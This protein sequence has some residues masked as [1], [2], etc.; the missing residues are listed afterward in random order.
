M[1]YKCRIS[2]SW[3][4]YGKLLRS[5]YN[6]IYTFCGQN[7]IGIGITF[8]LPFMFLMRLVS[9][10]AKLPDLTVILNFENELR[11]NDILKQHI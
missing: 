11:Q 1:E 9:G 5:Y 8:E 7:D 3:R 10:L 6:Q 4:C 2:L